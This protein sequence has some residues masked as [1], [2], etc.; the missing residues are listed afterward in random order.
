MII[1]SKETVKDNYDEII[2]LCGTWWNETLF[3]NLY[4]IEYAPEELMFIEAERLGIMLIILGRN[5]NGKLVSCYIGMKSPY[6]FNKNIMTAIELVWCIHKDYRT[7]SNLLSLIK[8]ISRVM[9]EERVN[10][11]SLAVPEEDKYAGLGKIMK[12]QG[13]N[14]METGYSKFR[15][16]NDSLP[17]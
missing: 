9:K 6:P 16:T 7:F 12:R 2:E 14:K 15:R 8:E 4:G 3:F 13:F 1:Y 11:Y 10:L 5:E 17:S